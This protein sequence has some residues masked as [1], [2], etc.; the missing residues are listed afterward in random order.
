MAWLL[1]LICLETAL[2]VA[3]NL[4]HEVYLGKSRMRLPGVL[5]SELARVK[6]KDEPNPDCP[7]LR[8]RASTHN[9]TLHPSVA[10]RIPEESGWQQF[11]LLEEC[12]RAC[13]VACHPLKWQVGSQPATITFILQKPKPHCTYP[14]STQRFT[15]FTFSQDVLP[16]IFLFWQWLYQNIQWLKYL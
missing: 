1:L 16:P 3:M 8:R 7:C 13:R 11:E 2:S 4:R 6:G 9:L 14:A 10:K 5:Y 12:Q 15:L